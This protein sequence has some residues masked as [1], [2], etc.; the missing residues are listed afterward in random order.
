MRYYRIVDD[1]G[2]TFAVAVG[3]EVDLMIA[4]HTRS[5]VEITKEEYAKIVRNEESLN[6]NGGLK[7]DGFNP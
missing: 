2:W 7:N 1:C 6:Q 4:P 5:A 3:D